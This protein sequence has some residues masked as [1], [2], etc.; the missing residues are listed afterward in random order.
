MSDGVELRWRFPDN[1][2]PLPAVGPVDLVDVFE[3]PDSSLESA[4]SVASDDTTSDTTSDEAPKDSRC[5]FSAKRL[6]KSSSTRDLLVLSCGRSCFLSGLL[7][8]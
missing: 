5:T 7:W 6:R 1:I 8:R 4:S 2:E 3:L